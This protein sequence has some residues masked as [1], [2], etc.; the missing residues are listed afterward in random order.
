MAFTHLHVHSEYSLL[1]GTAKINELVA[2]TKELGMDAIALTDHGVM[3]GVVDFYKAAK[4]AGIKPIIGCEVYITHGDR[5]AKVGNSTNESA[6]NHLVLLAENQTGYQNLIKLVSLGFTEGFYYRPRIDIELLREYHEGLIGLSACLSGAVPRTLLNATYAEAKELALLYNDIF[7]EGNF[8]IEIQN[9][10]LAEQR[11]VT[12]GLV[13]IAEETGIGLVATNDIHFIAAEDAAAHDVL[14]CIQTNT[15]VNDENRMIYEGGQYF[16]KSPAEMAALFPE[17][18]EAITN[19]ELIAARCNVEFEFHNYKLPRFQLPEGVNAFAYLRERV[20]E[21]LR[22]LYTD[23]SD[24]LIKRM[25]YELDTISNMGFIDYF[26]I[27]WDFIKYAKDNHIAVGPGRGSAAGSLVSYA[28]GITN[29]DPIAYD[30]LFERF[31]NPERIS[32]PDIDIDFCYERRQ[33]VIDYVNAKYGNDHV[34]QIIT[35]NT[36][37]AKGSVRDCGRALGMSYNEVDKVAKMIPFAL[38]MT[39]DMALEVSPELAAA[40]QNDESVKKLIDMAKRIEGLPRN[41]STHAAGVV[42]CDLPVSEYVPLNVNDGVVT[43]QFPMNTL[44][45]LGLLKIDF[46]GLRTLTV[47]NNALGLIKMN[48][49]IDIDIDRLDLTDQSVFEIIAQG[50]T[51]GV[52]Q[53]EAA[54]M[55][56][57][58]K[59]L[60]PRSI[61]DLTAGISL[62]RPGPMEFIPKYIR[63]KRSIGA[64]TYTHPLLEPILKNTYGCIVYQEQVMQIVRDLAGFSLARSDLVRRAMSKKKSDVMAQE[65]KN[66][67]FGNDEVPGCVKNGVPQNIAEQIF[68]EITD[69]SKYAFNKSHAA[70]YAVIAYQT[71][72]LKVYYP[73]EFMAALMT[74]VMDSESKVAEYIQESK[75]MG[76]EVLPPD[77]NMGYGQFT[78]SGKKI[79]Y[80]LNAIKN[81]GRPTVN[82]I[83]T[84][85][86]LGGRFNSL[87]EFVNRMGSGDIN[88]RA[89]ESLIWAGAFDSLGGR[90]SQYM[91]VYEAAINS[92]GQTKKRNIQGQVSLFDIGELTPADTYSDDLPDVAEYPLEQL[93]QG[94]KD[95]LGLYISGHPLQDYMQAMEGL[96]NTTSRDFAVE[97]DEFGNTAKLKDGTPVIMGGLINAISIKFTRTSNKQMAFVTIEDLYGTAE[98]I[99]FPNIYERCGSNIIKNQ[100][101]IV[102]GRISVREEEAPT[103]I[104]EEIKF[105]EQT[106]VAPK[107]PTNTTL[108]LKLSAASTYD[109]EALCKFLADFPGNT[110]VMVYEEATKERKKL[111]ERFNVDLKPLLLEKLRE[112]LGRANVVER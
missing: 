45:E 6:Y 69:F 24:A 83:V 16:L 100:V 55:K 30:L 98:V 42:I 14:I 106:P 112:M 64:I 61:D 89:L 102:R 8:F 77:I 26:L 54:G 31:L 2:K 62:Y 20:L 96:V 86:N 10:G 101:V 67:V 21:G 49:G 66:F 43:T 93:L 37:K 63:G 7:G 47:I 48:H 29:I 39:L 81:V 13:R 78:V 70:A 82:A 46:L 92:I 110:P 72:W 57:F 12:P 34:A 75:H 85:R 9:H 36:M 40:Y 59:D 17:Y 94:E 84:C 15:N 11:R 90:R 51:D 35:F 107:K 50:K 88:K 19:T 4:K 23:I 65:R 33:E 73:I 5:R 103:I 58:M 18:P 109:I 53:L 74:S 25:D 80:G 68:D 38:V 44:E 99:V 87:T 41:A 111:A 1:D 108:W 97:A 95:V 91:R 76:I 79:V 71:A 28:L 56:S 3:Y 22:V 52:F 104:C 32:M 27:T 105:L 60:Q